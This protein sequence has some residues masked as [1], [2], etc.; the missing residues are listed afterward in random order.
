MKVVFDYNQ[1]VDSGDA[2]VSA[3]INRVLVGSAAS[4][5]DEIHYQLQ[6]QVGTTMLFVS[7]S[8]LTYMVVWLDEN[9][10]SLVRLFNGGSE[11]GK[12]IERS[13]NFINAGDTLA[14]L[15]CL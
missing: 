1:F 6:R 8:N 3:R 7:K 11:G 13:L 5:C 2:A 9:C 10:V 14:K 4:I 12:V 15:L